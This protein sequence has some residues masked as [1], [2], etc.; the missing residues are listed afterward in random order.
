MK[1]FLSF[2]LL[3]PIVTHISSSQGIV[4]DLDVDVQAVLDSLVAEEDTD[5]DKKITI[6]DPHIPQTNRG[7]KRFWITSRGGT[8]YEVTGVYSLSNLLQEL[9]L[10]KESGRTEFRAERI[11]E[12][13]V[14]R[15]SRMIREHY[16]DGLTRRIDEEHLP[17]I[18]ADDKARTTDGN[19]YLYIP[20]AD[21][22]A[23]NYFS[24]VAKE[25]PELRLNVVQLP[26]HITP[27]YVRH[28]DGRHGLLPLALRKRGSR[29]EGVPFVVPGG[30]F[31]EMYGWDSY[32]IVLGLLNDG[33]VELARDMVENFVYEIDHYGKILNANR[34]YFL[35]RSQPPFLTSMIKAVYARLPRNRETRD[36]LRRSVEAAMKEYREVWMSPA[37]LTP[38]GLN[39]YFDEGFGQPPEVEPG[40]F[41][42]AYLKFAAKYGMSPKDLERAYTAGNLRAPDIDDY[43]V[44]DRCMRESGHDTSYRLENCCAHLATVDLNSLLYKFEIDIA[45]ILEKEFRGSLRL[46]GGR[47]E[48]SRDWKNLARQRKER[49]TRFLWNTERGMFFDYDVNLQK[50]RQYVSATILYPLWA[51]LAT[52]E[53]A[54]LL[55]KNALPL[56][57]MPGGIVSS[58]E[59]SRGPLGPERPPRQWDYP[60]GW[61]PHQMIV[62]QG[63]LNYGYAREAHRLIYRWLF[64][65]TL[66]AANYN[67]TI[68]EKFDVVLRSHQVFAEYGNVGT[69]FAYITR[70]GFG[71]TNASFQVGVSLLPPHL[72][73]RLNQ[74]I[75]PEWI[76]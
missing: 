69:A 44:H 13:P 6:D 74:L 15:F 75:P 47:T 35:T 46:A 62:W 9:T 43:F 24:S 33:R 34:T 72:K 8:R 19:S 50:Q 73:D 56:L 54:A 57:E 45:T 36:W 76:F 21:T 23:L 27:E 71:W 28:L 52:A 67:G 66:N 25:R 70:E 58:T 39:R 22:F 12:P 41:D 31:N 53:Q 37:R 26:E 4:K 49:M 55:V 61:A 10:A 16:W 3:L 40:H 38:I 2:L 60:N 20:S 11:F 5:N 18:L 42:A 30:R 32:F 14:D 29:V 59:D 64:T 7:D 48:R 1:Q 17:P 68:P 51:E 65:M 63:L